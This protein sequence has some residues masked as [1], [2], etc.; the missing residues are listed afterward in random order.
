MDFFFKFRTIVMVT[1]I[2]KMQ[3]TKNKNKTKII[4]Q[5][6]IC[7]EFQQVFKKLYDINWNILLYRNTPRSNVLGI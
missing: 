7:I 3:L 1:I 6:G 2:F 5:G 4:L